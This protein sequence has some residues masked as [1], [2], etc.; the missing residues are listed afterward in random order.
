ME[1]QVTHLWTRNPS[2]GVEWTTS[3]YLLASIGHPLEGPGKSPI[4]L[5]PPVGAIVL[6]WAVR[7][8]NL[9][10]VHIDDVPGTA[11]ETLGMKGRFM[12]NM[13]RFD[14]MLAPL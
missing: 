10:T 11:F 2:R 6:T 3:H 12:E 7:G 5:I 4:A 1:E 9:S 14:V 13:D 8:L